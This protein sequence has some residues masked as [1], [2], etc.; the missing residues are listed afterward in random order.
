MA[1]RVLV[2][3]APDL[4]EV[5]GFYS[6]LAGVLAGFSFA[7]L[8]ALVASKRD[9]GTAT[10]FRWHSVAPLTSAFVALVAS[11]LDYALVAGETAGTNRVAAVQTTAGMGFSIA[12]IMLV[13]SILVLLAD[14]GFG[15]A[16]T[17]L[18]KNLTVVTLPPLLVLLMWSGVRDHLVQV[19]D[20][21]S[22]L[23]W[24]DWVSL[25][26]LAT[27]AGVGASLRVRF[28]NRSI[29]Q[30]KLVT[31]LAS[32]TA[33]IAFLSLIGTTALISL[34]TTEASVPDIIPVVATLIVGAFSIAVAYSA[35]RYQ[36]LSDADAPPA[37]EFTDAS[38]SE[39]HVTDSAAQD[40]DESGVTQ[41]A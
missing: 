37:E 4:P 14:H 21:D 2:A 6:Q 1:L 13:Y 16:A 26:T 7:A 32:G 22:R 5:A 33:H 9:S 38:A 11:S 19:H 17:G 10:S 29:E 31:R 41:P 39:G 18:L 36:T 23:L 27:V 25:G 34:T 40:E 15:Q 12:G 35:A 30:D 24:A 28:R 20:S 3:S 8:V